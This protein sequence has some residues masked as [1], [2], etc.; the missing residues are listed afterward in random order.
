MTE[1]MPHENGESGEGAATPSAL[2]ENVASS[3]GEEASPSP[4]ATSPSA[5]SSPAPSRRF[6]DLGPRLISGFV[7]IVLMI[8]GVLL[9]N[10]PCVVLL[11]VAAGM[12][13]HEFFRM[14][15]ESHSGPAEILGTVAAVLYPPVAY[16]LGLGGIAVLTLVLMLA[17]L[18]WF[19]FCPR[20]TVADVALTF[21]GAVYTGMLLASAMLLRP[22]L[23][24][25]WGGVAVL[26]IFVS[27][28][29]NDSFAY[30]VGS[31]FGKHKMVPKISPKKSWEGFAG[32]LVGSMLV[33]LLF[34]AVPGVDMSWWQALLCGIVCG[35]MSVV[36]DLVESRIK[37]NYGVKDSGKI[38]PGH[39]GLL[40]RMDSL[41]FAIPTAVI[42]LQVFGCIV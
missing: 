26:I 42:L 8:A 4:S 30:L 24:E 28:W 23:S 5:P 31:R 3:E 29:I 36:G 1:E 10:I 27:V 13:A 34:L 38:M 6:S 11:S 16:W 12:C 7:Y 35:L 41:L 20:A 32:G 33:W 39:G 15:R 17:L 40:D 21:F 14:S 22:Q 18:V 19:V 9:G 2:G 25:P 37:R